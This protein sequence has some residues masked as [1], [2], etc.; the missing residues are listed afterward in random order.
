M[1]FVETWGEVFS[2]SLQGIWFGVASFV[3][4]L[5]I[6]VVIFAIGWVLASLV[7]KLVETVFRS[8]KIDNGLRAAG[9]EETIK[10]AGYNLNSGRF[11]GTLVRWFVIVVFLVAAFDALGLTQVNEFL[12]TVV[13]GYLPRVIVSVLILMVAVIV[14]GVMQKLVVGSARAAHISSANFLGS[15]TKW[16]IWIF[17]VLT[18]LFQL[19]IAAAFLQTLFTAVVAAFALALGLAFG[20]GGKETAAEILSK[21]RHEIQERN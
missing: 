21:A 16:A 1:M 17:A 9:V 5:V 15:V 20:L 14:G 7:E 11:V 4:D 3:P 2:R 10:R 18:A 13:L 6:A 12:A 8:L 19:G